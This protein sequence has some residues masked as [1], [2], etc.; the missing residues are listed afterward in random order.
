MQGVNTVRVM[1][2]STQRADGLGEVIV[3]QMGFDALPAE[4]TYPLEPYL[5]AEERAAKLSEMVSALFT[6]AIVDSGL[7]KLTITRRD[8]AD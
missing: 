1:I 6:K 3:S 7:G 8:V 2:R 5:L 4:V